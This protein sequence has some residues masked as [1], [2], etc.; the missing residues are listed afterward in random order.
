M[1]RR[2]YEG[3]SGS[4]GPADP[5]AMPALDDVEADD[6]GEDVSSHGDSD[7]EEGDLPLAAADAWWEVRREWVE[8]VEEAG[9]IIAVPPR[10]RT[11]QQTEHFCLSL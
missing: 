5:I 8:A 1:G 11:E 7:M 9:P 6:A 4:A 2:W 3:A 10:F